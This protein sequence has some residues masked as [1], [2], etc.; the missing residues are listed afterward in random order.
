MKIT[1][2]CRRI[3]NNFHDFALSLALKQR[4]GVTRKW[5]KYAQGS[6]D[7]VGVVSKC[8]MGLI[9]RRFHFLGSV[10]TELF[11]SFTPVDP[12]TLKKWKFTGHA[13][14]VIFENPF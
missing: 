5:S 14:N 8:I 7:W 11:Q 10:H 12:R 2:I 1:F 4:L 3:A 6:E 9:G 13:D